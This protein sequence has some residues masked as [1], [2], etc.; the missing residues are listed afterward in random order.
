MDRVKRSKKSRMKKR[1]ED[2]EAMKQ[3]IA[4]ELGLWDKVQQEGWSGLSASESGRLGGVFSVRKKKH[5]QN[6]KLDENA[7]GMDEV[8]QE[9]MEHPYGDSDIP[10]VV[11]AAQEQAA[12]HRAGLSSANHQSLEKQE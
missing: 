11:Y 1:P 4:K 3:E 9:E 2:W 6:V 10:N 7:V 5:Q 8:R 12:F